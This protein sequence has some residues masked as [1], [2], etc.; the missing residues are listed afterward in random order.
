MSVEWTLKSMIKKRMKRLKINEPFESFYRSDFDI[1][2]YIQ[3]LPDD[4]IVSI[5]QF[6]HFKEF[7]SIERINKIKTKQQEIANRSIDDWIQH[8]KKY[9]LLYMIK[10]I[11]EEIKFTKQHIR[12]EFLNYT[13][14]IQDKILRAS[15]IFR[16]IVYHD[17]ICIN[18]DKFMNLLFYRQWTMNIHEIPDQLIFRIKDSSK[19]KPKYCGQTYTDMEGVDFVSYYREIFRLSYSPGCSQGCSQYELV[20]K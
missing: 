3:K 20:W 16:R 10:N 6:L 7:R 14:H 8:L 15:K 2:K 19:P 4:I 5:G 18:K 9:P 11:R 12:I 17:D 1:Q 13:S